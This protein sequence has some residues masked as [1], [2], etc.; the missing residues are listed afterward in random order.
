MCFTYSSAWTFFSNHIGYFLGYAMTQS[1]LNL[2]IVCIFCNVCSCLVIFLACT[3]VSDWKLELI[4]ILPC[5]DILQDW[6]WKKVSHGI[7]KDLC[8][9]TTLWGIEKLL[10]VCHCQYLFIICTL[11]PIDHILLSS[12]SYSV[13]VLQWSTHKLLQI[14]E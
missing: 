14:I 10:Q 4:V 1:L 13:K 3:L 5:S 11:M 6:T 8:R 12:F 9:C 2:S 7:E